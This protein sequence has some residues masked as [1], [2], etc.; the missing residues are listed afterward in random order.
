MGLFNRNLPYSALQDLPVARASGSGSVLKD[1]DPLRDSTLR[2]YRICLLF[3]SA[4]PKPG[5]KQP[6]QLD[7]QETTP[8]M[9]WFGG[10]TVAPGQPYHSKTLSDKKIKIIGCLDGSVGKGAGHQAREPE[11]GPWGVQSGKNWFLQAPLS[12]TCLLR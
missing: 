8:G 10:S 1:L 2:S 3:T 7:L 11:L 4:H 12:S 5:R 9:I 6:W